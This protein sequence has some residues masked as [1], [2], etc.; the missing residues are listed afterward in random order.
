MPELP[1]DMNGVIAGRKTLIERMGAL[2]A[3]I[4][5]A[6]DL[7]TRSLRADGTIYACG[8]GGSATQAQ[9]F[10]AELVGRFKK[11]RPC[12]R[13]VALNDNHAILTSLSNDYDFDEVF[14]RQVSG[15]ADA[16]DCLLALSTSG[17]SENVVRACAA[18]RRNDVRIVSLTGEAGGRVADASDIALRVPDTDTARIQ[19]MHLLIIHLLCQLVESAMFPAGS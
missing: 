8:N 15:L 1:L 7:F 9:H 12:L 14:A 5:D 4:Q 10:T 17:E 19:E 2:T 11:D 16:G 6:A 13:A 3:G 18:A